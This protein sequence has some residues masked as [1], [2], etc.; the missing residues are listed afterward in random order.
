MEGTPRGVPQLTTAQQGEGATPAEYAM[1]L[2]ARQRLG[3]LGSL[4]VLTGRL[5]DWAAVVWERGQARRLSGTRRHSA[6]S[7][8]AT[9]DL[10]AAG[11]LDAV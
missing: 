5:A 11:H 8:S 7:Q 6:S 10:M 3:R 1:R 2:P 9:E 4:L